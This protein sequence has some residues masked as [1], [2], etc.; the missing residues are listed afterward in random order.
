MAAREFTISG[1]L[2]ATEN[3]DG[4]GTWTVVDTATGKTLSRCV[5]TVGE[6]ADLFE[7]GPERHH[8]LTGR[9]M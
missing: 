2:K 7:P 9:A 4:H 8:G 1:R 5:R 6:L 3:Q